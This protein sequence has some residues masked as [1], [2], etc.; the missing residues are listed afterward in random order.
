MT[1]IAVVGIDCRF[2]GAPDKDAFWR[3]LMDGVVTDTEVPLQRWDIDAYY[4]PDGGAGS[5]NTRRAHFIDDVDAFDNDFF[6]IAP[7]EAAALDPQQ[8]LLL[9][10][11]WR[12]LEDAGI[13]PRSLAGT[14][15]GVFVGMMSS[16]WGLLQILDFARLSALRGAG[17][18]YFMT[19]NR[20]SYHLNLTGPSMAIDSACSSSLMA[21]H[22]GCVA[23]RSGETDTVIAAGA[24]LVLT[25]ALSIFY[26]QSGLSAPDGRCKPFGQSADGIGR[27]EGVAAVVLRRLDDAVADGQPIYAVVKSSV[28]NHDGRSNGITAPNRGGQ[29]RLMRRALELAELEAGQIDFVE[30][31][32]TGTVLGDMIEANALGDIHKMRSGQPCLLGSV[33]GNIGHTEGSAGIAAF[34]KACLALHHRMLPP[35]LF[36]GKANPRLR[37]DAH[38]LRLADSPQ[39]LPANGALGAVSS[40]GLGGSNAHAVLESAPPAAA[41]QPGVTGVLTVSAPSEQALRRNV[42]SIAAA[43]HTL[44]DQRLASWCRTTDVVKRSHRYC[45]V[46]HGDRAT[47]ADGLREFLAGARADLA[48]SAPMSKAPARVGLF[49]SGQG[50]QYPGMTRPLYDANHTYR[51]HLHAAAAALNP[52]LT[53]DLLP[54]IFGDDPGLHHT[55]VAQPALFAVSYAL[56]KTLLETGIRPPFAVGHSVGELAAACLGGVLSIEDAARIVAIRGRLMGALP[57]GG[58]MIAV[59]L[60][61]EQAAA[62]IA[63]EPDCAIAAVNGPRSMVISGTAEAVARAYAAVRE[64]GGKAVNLEVSHAFHSPLMEPVVARFRCQLSGL[65]PRPSQF[66]LFSTVHGR[67]IEGQEMDSDYWA[68]QICAPVRF[69]DA[70]RAATRAASTDYVAEAGPRSTLLAMATQ[71]GLPPQIRRLSLCGGPDSDGQELLATAAT[72]LRDGHSPDLS[73]L[74]GGPAGPL[75]RIPPYVFDASSRFWFDGGVA[76]MAAPAQ[77]AVVTPVAVGEQ[78]ARIPATPEKAVLTV[79]ADVGGYSGA[80][81]TRSSRLAEDLGYDSLLQLR[82]IDRLRAEYPQLRHVS[83]REVL[84]K[85][86]SVGDLVDFVAQWFDRTDV[87]G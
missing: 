21:I 19:A 38:G 46:F 5:M 67:E 63:N 1:F 14:P 3:L 50:T 39:Q 57:P 23:L 55:G 31:H 45:F 78:P 66:P 48:S 36:G 12:A 7:I 70:V 58:A 10:A 47:L 42:E 68:R 53:T 34:I 44:D 32:G 54:V 24:N 41:P 27:G 16:E 86:R 79:I 62:L 29:V 4:D 52:H 37:L 51:E 84:P 85:V 26:T 33:K 49:F 82:L 8:R 56:G 80:E 60:G 75:Q 43:L 15:T 13:N 28:A 9:Q 6:G 76:A 71:C 2:P 40:F 22:Q 72:M 11:S 77:P 20:I 65:A 17:S 18:G 59:D 83:V 74:Y 30:A 81:L 64:R 35:T 25:P 87:T 69:F 73:P 61:V